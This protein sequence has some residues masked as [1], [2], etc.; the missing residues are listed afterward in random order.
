MFLLFSQPDDFNNQ[1][2]VNTTTPIQNFNISAFAEALDMGNPLGG[3]FI[4]VGP[5][6]TGTVF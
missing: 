6:P 2:L 4:L 3:T 5:D 1:T